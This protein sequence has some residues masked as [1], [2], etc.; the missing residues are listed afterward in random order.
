MKRVFV[1]A[2][3]LLLCTSCAGQPG[4]EA[5]TT[6]T[7][8]VTTTVPTTAESTAAPTTTE[9]TTVAPAAFQ[10]VPQYAGNGLLGG[11]LL[12]KELAQTAQGRIYRV[13]LQAVRYS[14]AEDASLALGFFYVQGEKILRVRESG[15]AQLADIKAGRFPAEAE[16]VFQKTP[17][18][19]ALP[20]AQKGIHRSISV[21]DE[22]VFYRYLDDRAG[23]PR[24][25]DMVWQIGVGLLAYRYYDDDGTLEH[26]LR[27]TA[28]PAAAKRGPQPILPQ[29][30]AKAQRR[31][32]SLPQDIEVLGSA[33]GEELYT[34]FAVE[35][36][37]ENSIYFP[38]PQFRDSV[39]GAKQRNK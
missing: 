23:A 21:Q 9:P 2:L 4:G 27:F 37:A 6:T 24:Y 12:V 30:A 11:E 10:A 33:R 32:P 29:A 13:R 28:E 39:P 20:T 31:W 8:A 26:Y 19:D 14:T 16:V 25:E 35:E 22:F 17:L 1:I 38:F 5:G 7:A 36:S 34:R 18:A 3:L 15:Q